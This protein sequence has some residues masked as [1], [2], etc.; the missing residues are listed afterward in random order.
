MLGFVDLKSFQGAYALAVDGIS[1]P[2]TRAAMHAALT[3]MSV[4]DRRAPDPV[5]KPMPSDAEFPPAMLPDGSTPW[6]LGIGGLAAVVIAA[7][8]RLAEWWSALLN[9][10]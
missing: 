3:S 2:K 8:D 5:A 4:A 9:M 7:G 10:F 6:L 1:G